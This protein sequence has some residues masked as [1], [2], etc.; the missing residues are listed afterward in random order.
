LILSTFLCGLLGQGLYTSCL[1]LHL[2]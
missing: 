1:C 2:F